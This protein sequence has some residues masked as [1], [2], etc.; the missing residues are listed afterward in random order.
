MRETLQRFARDVLRPAAH[1][2]DHDAVFPDSIRTQSLE[3]GLN[4]YAVPEALGGMAAEQSVVTY[5][6]S[7]RPYTLGFQSAARSLSTGLCERD[8]ASG[9]YCRHGG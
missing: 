1:Q 9:V 3:L 6:G 2:S 4:F 7:Q 5:G 8:S